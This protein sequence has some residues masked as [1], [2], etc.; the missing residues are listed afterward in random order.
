MGRDGNSGDIK[1]VEGLVSAYIKK[2]N[3][4]ILLTVACESKSTDWC[5]GFDAL[6]TL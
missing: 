3:C 2:S 6:T 5:F 4:I 1:L